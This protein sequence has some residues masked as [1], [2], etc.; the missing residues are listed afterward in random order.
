MVERSVTQFESYDCVKLENGHLTLWLTR[1]CGPRVI[2]LS[3]FG[4]KKML[5][6]LPD[7]KYEYPEQEDYYFHGDHRLWYA[8]EQPDTTYIEDDQPVEIEEID[9]GIKLVQPVD[10]PTGVQKSVESF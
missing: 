10:Q 9:N 2:G 6:L 4:G 8:P 5:A 3:V 1:S 7:A